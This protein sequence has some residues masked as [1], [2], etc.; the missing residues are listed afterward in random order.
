M[1]LVFF[2]VAYISSDR[3]W[4]DYASK[5]HWTSSQESEKV[6]QG[7]KEVSGDGIGILTRT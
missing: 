6:E 3:T 7:D 5:D 2:E 4:N 1:N